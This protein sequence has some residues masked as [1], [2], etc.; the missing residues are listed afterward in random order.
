MGTADTQSP[1]LLMLDGDDAKST[2]WWSYWP[3]RAGS[4]Q[5]TLSATVSSVMRR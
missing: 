3:Y 1:K 5:W 2:S 4:L